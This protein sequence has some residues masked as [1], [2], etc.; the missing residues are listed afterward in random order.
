[1]AGVEGLRPDQAILVFGV[2]E[3]FDIGAFCYSTRETLRVG[4]G[5]RVRGLKV[6]PSTFDSYSA[7]AVQISIKRFSDLAKTSNARPETIASWAGAYRQFLNYT[8]PV[9]YSEIVADKSAAQTSF[10]RFVEYLKKRVAA[11]ELLPRTA[12]RLQNAVLK[13]LSAITGFDELHQGID[14]N[15]FKGS[16]SCSTEPPTY[17]EKGK[18]LSL[19]SALFE[20]LSKLCLE[21][22]TYPYALA[23]PRYLSIPNDNLWVFPAMTWCMPPHRL[24]DRERLSIPHWA[25][26]YEA[27]TIAS[28]ESIEHRYQSKYSARSAVNNAVAAVAKANRDFK[29]DF[30]RRNAGFFAHNAFLLLFIANTGIN[31]AGAIELLW[32]A[33]YEISAE[34]QAFRTIKYRAGGKPVVFEIQ[35]TF[36]SSFKKFSKLRAYLLGDADC[37]TLFVGRTKDA[38]LRRTDDVVPMNVWGIANFYIALRQ[39]DPNLPILKSK[40]LRAGKSDWLFLEKEDPSTVALVLQNSEATAL[41]SYAEGSPRVQEEEFASFFDGLRSA[42]ISKD[43]KVRNAIETAV[44][45]CANRGSPKQM[46]DAPIESDCSLPEGC[47]FCDKYKVHADDRDVRKLASCRYCIERTAHLAD[48]DEQFQSLF[49]PIF[50]RIDY[51]LAEIDR[52]SPGLVSRIVQEVQAGELDPYWAAKMEMLINLELVT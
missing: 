49:G 2:S 26:D 1:M 47:L 16:K 9:H 42:V 38:L 8:N 7:S 6:D 32:N 27:G 14:L 50:E 41:E 18:V 13:V 36:L 52:R 24:A 23:I 12:A 40:K 51:L 21:E 44:G 33:D 20:G 48:D 43:E 3:T 37:E 45:V 25:F 31:L 5:G 17:E 11:N 39:L 15:D 19:C 28:A 4:G 34:R 29:S 35:A 10:R 46:V 30:Y 22:S